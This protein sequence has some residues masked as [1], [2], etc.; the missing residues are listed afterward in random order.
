VNCRL[1]PGRRQGSN[2][3][4]VAEGYRSQ[5]E[6]PHCAQCEKAFAVADLMLTVDG[7]WSCQPCLAL[8]QAK[9]AGKLATNNMSR[10]RHDGSAL[11]ARVV[12]VLL[13]MPFLGIGLILAIALFWSM[14][15][16]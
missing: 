10:L 13:L 4:P 2:S 9:V 12:V 15:S 1:P 8:A 16:H 11:F 6:V 3:A 5:A 7:A 14:C